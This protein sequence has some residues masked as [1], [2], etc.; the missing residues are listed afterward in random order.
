MKDRVLRVQNEKLATTNE[1]ASSE[2]DS[3]RGFTDQSVSA[4]ENQQF[5]QRPGLNRK[6][7]NTISIEE[8]PQLSIDQQLNKIKNEYKA[9]DNQE[10]KFKNTI[11]NIKNNKE[12]FYPNESTSL[13]KQYIEL[14]RDLKTN[15]KFMQKEL[16][17]QQKK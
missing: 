16:K 3:T 15:L 7:D 10:K 11:N 2:I 8:L 12:N 4:A 9:Y 5:T 14:I 6:W 13:F 1:G 17:K